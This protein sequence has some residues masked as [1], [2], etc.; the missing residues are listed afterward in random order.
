MK[1]NLNTQGM[2]GARTAFFL[3]SPNLLCKSE[4]CPNRDSAG[5]AEVQGWGGVG[6]EPGW[7]AAPLPAFPGYSVLICKLGWL[8]KSRT[9]EEMKQVRGKEPRTL[10]MV[11]ARS[12]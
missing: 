5:R 12:Q 6:D 10:C 1:K 2:R 8:H 9:S 3:L 7:A 4:S 11:T